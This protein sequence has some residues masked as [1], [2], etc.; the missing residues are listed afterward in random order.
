MVDGWHAL[1]A[2]SKL[3]IGSLLEFRSL[4]YWVTP[5]LL[6]I[7]ENNSSALGFRKFD[8]LYGDKITWL[9]C[10]TPMFP[11]PAVSVDNLWGI[12]IDGIWVHVQEWRVVSDCRQ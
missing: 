1:A 6:V 10:G 9:Q 3:P 11:R 8:I 4:Q 5:T 7:N 12:M 2:N